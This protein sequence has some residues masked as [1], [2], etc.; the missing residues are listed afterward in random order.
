MKRGVFLLFT[1][2]TQQ[3]QGNVMEQWQEYKSF[4]HDAV[5]LL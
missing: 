2:L 4:C 1:V 5:S 3:H